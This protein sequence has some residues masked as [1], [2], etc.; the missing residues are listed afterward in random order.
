MFCY[1]LDSCMLCGNVEPNSWNQEYVYHTAHHGLLSLYSA[2]VLGQIVL[3][4]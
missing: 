1:V 4:Q 2:D 3:C